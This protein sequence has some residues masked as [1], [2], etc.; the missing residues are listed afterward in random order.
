MGDTV[1]VVY[2]NGVQ[3]GD[4]TTARSCGAKGDGATVDTDAIQSLMTSGGVITDGDYMIDKPLLLH[5]NSRL[6]GSARNGVSI[7]TSPSFAGTEIFQLCDKSTILPALDHLK[8][9]STNP[10]VAAVRQVGTNWVLNGSFTNLIL[11]TA[12]GILLDSYSQQCVVSNIYASAV[13]DQLLKLLGNA[14]IISDLDLENGCGSSVQP[15]DYAASNSGWSKIQRK[16][17]AQ[18]NSRR[19]WECQ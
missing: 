3:P 15:S 16:H 11:N 9:I 19:A 14:N 13:M 10:N 4:R 1:R 18:H 12:Y 6:F 5:S 7:R 2:S 17:P 8:L